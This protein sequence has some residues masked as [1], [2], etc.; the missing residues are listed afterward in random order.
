MTAPGQRDTVAATFSYT[1]SL[2][3]DGLTLA[4]DE[5]GRTKDNLHVVKGS[6]TV[7]HSAGE[8]TI[9]ASLDNPI[10]FSVRSGT[11]PGGQIDIG[12]DSDP[13]ITS[14]NYKTVASD[15]TPSKVQ[16]GRPPRTLFWAEDLTTVHERFHGDELQKQGR[17]AVTEA[18][19]WLNAQTA[20]SLEDV[21]ALYEQALVRMR[22]SVEDAMAAPP[23]YEER[24]YGD[25]APLY[26]ERA[27]AVKKKGDAGK[28]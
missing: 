8:Y 24:A 1:A 4:A 25:G 13:D 16:N 14:S 7:T 21:K 17:R 22:T 9:K 6:A 20:A 2:A 10:V 5:F 27:N 28:Y 3:Q 11:G 23:G 18:R 19:N 12:S 26:L 15:L